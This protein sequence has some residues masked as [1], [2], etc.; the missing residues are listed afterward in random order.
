MD[1]S[2]IPQEWKKFLSRVQEMFPTAT[3]AGG[4]LRDLIAENPIKD[5][6]IYI[7]DFD[8]DSDVDFDV[9]AEH[10]GVKYVADDSTE[11]RDHLK[12]AHDVKDVKRG[13][14]EKYAKVDPRYMNQETVGQRALCE[15]FINYI[16]DVHYNGTLYQL[17]FI[18]CD[19]AKMV[20]ED[21]DFNICKIMYDG[22]HFIITEEFWYDMEHKQ[23]T[24]S[25]KIS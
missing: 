13:A 10:L 7:H 14:H 25:G 15:S 16:V 3:I 23:L 9:V 1:H 8:F 2:I 17:I 12:V 6:D 21:F 18:E 19:P 11:V 4:S 20:I 24:I 5:V 22:T